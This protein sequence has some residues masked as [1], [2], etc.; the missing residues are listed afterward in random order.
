MQNDTISKRFKENKINPNSEWI[1]IDGNKIHKTCIIYDNVILGVNNIIY[2]FSVIGLPGFI[3]D[4][5]KPF[6]KII[7]GDNNRIGTHTSIM[8]GL[9]GETVIGNDNIIMNYVNIGHDANIG[10]KNE[11]GTGSI[12]AGWTTIGDLNKIKLNC[13]FRNRVSI[14]NNNL[15]GMGSLVIKSFSNNKLVYGN[16]AEIISSNK[17]ES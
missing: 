12:V 4:L 11:I 7:I 5:N 15:I 16:P 14:G 3:R 10:S 9:N 8:A 6:G 2:P 17:K 1:I 13:V